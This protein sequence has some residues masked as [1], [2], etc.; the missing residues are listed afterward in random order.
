MKYSESEIRQYVAE[1]EVRSQYK[2]LPAT[3]ADAKAAAKT[4][5]F[6]ASS[7]PRTIVEYY[8]K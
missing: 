8:T 4:S 1:E 7:L 3:L 2:T 5:E 6:I